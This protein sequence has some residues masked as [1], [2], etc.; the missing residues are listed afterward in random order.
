[1]KKKLLIADD[2]DPIRNGIAKYIQLHTDRF[3]KI[4]LASNGQ[5]AIDIIF[6]DK[7]DILFLDV[8]M[9]L[10][11]G[12]EVMQEAKRAGILP[13]T[14][15]LSGYD[16][17]KYCQQALRLGAKEYLLKPVRSSDI[18]HMLNR[19]ADELFGEERA[20][21]EPEP[22]ERNPLVELAQEYVAEHYDENL[23]LSDAA[24]KVGVSTGYLSTLFQKRLGKGFVDYVNEVRIEH[25][26][27]YLRQTYW[28]TYE[29][30]YK[31]GFRDEKYFSKVFKKVTGRSP[32]EYRKINQS[33]EMWKEDKK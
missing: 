15:I 32:S 8:Q 29:I 17:F 21:K 33:G 4:C 30:A 31:V 6:R 14:M 18:L 10:K 27:T 19:A 2:E 22:G 25:A 24:E 16:E 1:M 3:D 28:K 20:I 7:P 12:I 26:C 9:P 5:E 11:T 13:Y 23:M